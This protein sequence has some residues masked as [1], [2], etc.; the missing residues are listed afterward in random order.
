MYHSVSSICKPYTQKPLVLYQ[1]ETVPIPILDQKVKAHSYT[2]LQIRKPYIALNSETYISLRQQE[3]RTCKRI[4]YEFYC[5]KLFVVKHKTSYSCKS[6]IHFNLDTDIIKENCNFQF[7]FNKT[8]IT[9]TIFNGGNEIILAN[10]LNN[11]HLIC[12]AIND[13]PVK[14][15]SHSYVLVNRSVFCNCSI[16]ADNHYLLE[17]IAA[18]DNRDYNLLCFSQ[19]TWL[20]QITWIC[21]LISLNHS[22]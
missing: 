16:E 1:L 11:K 20:L 12:N 15:P 2:H 13:I 22:C 9:S 14:I 8:D 5:K 17:S 3:L 10:W 21:F 7:Y 4:G 18:C 6:A 19:L